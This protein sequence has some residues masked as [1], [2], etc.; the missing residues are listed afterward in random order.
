[1]NDPVKKPLVL[2]EG[3]QDKSVMEE[4]ARRAGLQEKLDFRE[5]GGK[6]RL[7]DYL[8]MLKARPEYVSG[9]YPRILVTRDADDDFGSS[10]QAIRDAIAEELG[11]HLDAPGHWVTTNENREIAAWIVPGDG[12]TGMIET[13]CVDSSSEKFPKVNECLELF[14]ECLACVYGAAMHQKARFAIW[15]I[16]AQGAGAKDLMSLEYAIPNLP[17]DWDDEAFKPLRDLLVRVAG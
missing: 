15:T 3:K 6:Y 9:E 8:N 5:Y 10:W 7:R 14:L 1:M 11:C 16:A 4:L 17:I 12:R 13:M 2:C